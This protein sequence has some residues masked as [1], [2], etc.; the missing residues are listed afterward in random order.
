MIDWRLAERLAGAV[1]GEGPPGRQ[2]STQ[3][4]SLVAASEAL[5]VDYTDITPTAVLPVPE[6]VDRTAWVRANLRSVRRLV[7]PLTDRVG[8]NLGPLRGPARAA[9]GLV[10]SAEVGVVLGFLGQ[11]VLGQYDLALLD[12]DVPP[13]LLFVAPNLEQ[14]TTRLGA[15]R[16]DLWTWV[17]LHEVTH[18]VQFTGVPW[19]RDHLAG[20]LRELLDS[21][22][23][24]VDPKRLTRLPARDDLKGLIDAVRDGGLMSVVARPEQ[25]ELLDRVQ[26]T[27]ALI[28]G[29]A[30]HVMD[31]VGEQQL[32]RLPELRAS[33]ERRRREQPPLVKLIGRML[34]LELKLRQYK[35]GKAFCDTVVEAGGIEALNRAWATPANVPTAAELEDPKAWLVRTAPETPAP[36]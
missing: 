21:F 27:M 13:R 20:M 5:V 17:A 18:A 30:E 10:V 28:E 36:A 23:V 9:S 33:L 34:G 11:R 3:L 1:A 22:D 32:P 19:L 14:A 29:H 35:L 8:E 24:K 16:D 15:D 31:A 26:A 6:S 4:A 7:E 2:P 12:A 25:R